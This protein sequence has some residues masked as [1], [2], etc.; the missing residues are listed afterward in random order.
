MRSGCF[1]LLSIFC[2][3]LTLL[4]NFFLCLLS[5]GLDGLGLLARQTGVALGL[6]A[7]QADLLSFPLLLYFGLFTLEFFLSPPGT[8]GFLGRLLLGFLLLTR[9]LAGFCFAL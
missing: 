1:S 9:C 5:L 7:R 2:R 4:S 8:L 6:L 3:S